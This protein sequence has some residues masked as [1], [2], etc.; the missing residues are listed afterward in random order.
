[1]KRRRLKSPSASA[2]RFH[3]SLPAHLNSCS[4]S[5]TLPIRQKSGLYGR[6]AWAAVTRPPCWR[7]AIGTSIE[8][9]QSAAL[10][11]AASGNLHPE[12][13]EYETLDAY[14]AGG[15]YDTLRSYREGASTRDGV[16]ELV[17]S[18]GLRG[19][20]G[21]GFPSGRKW[22]FVRMEPKPRLMA[23]NADEGEPGTFKDRYFL[24]RQPHCFLEG[25][26]IAAWAVEADTV[27]IYLR[28][29]YPGLPRYTEEG[30]CPAGRGGHSLNPDR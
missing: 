26:L 20:G 30:D 25:M 9:T 10:E 24:E 15:G 1:M 5:E 22:S 3:A 17:L 28:D 11:I 12:I 27:Y 6:L 13:P 29:E 21:A 7:L 16:Q 8:P 19:L 23:V 18:S 4:R 2:T 14:L